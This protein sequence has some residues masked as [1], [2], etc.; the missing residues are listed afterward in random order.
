MKQAHIESTV[1][2]LDA[3]L[4]LAELDIETLRS[5]LEFLSRQNT[6][7]LQALNA[8]VDTSERNIGY[9]DSVAQATACGLSLLRDDHEAALDPGTFLDRLSWLLF[10][11]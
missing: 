7:L 3:D 6:A 5:D 9:L 1:V 11:Y 2:M 4:E 8:R 10:G